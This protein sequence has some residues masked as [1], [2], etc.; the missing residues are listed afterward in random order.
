VTFPMNELARTSAV[1]AADIRTVRDFE[2]ALLR[3]ARLLSESLR[4]VALVIA[5]SVC[6][7]VT[8][9]F[10]VAGA[11]MLWPS[12]RLGEERWSDREAVLR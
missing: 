10:A 5:R 8:N 12:L 6:P 2:D 1:E 3:C 7:M 9:D 11:M 4:R